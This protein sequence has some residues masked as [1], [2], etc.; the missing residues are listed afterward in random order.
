M[1]APLDLAMFANAEAIAV[2]CDWRYRRCNAEILKVSRHKRRGILA[3]AHRS[4]GDRGRNVD[5]PANALGRKV[6]VLEPEHFAALLEEDLG[7]PV[8]HHLLDLRIGVNWCG[9]VQERVEGSEA[10]LDVCLPG[11]AR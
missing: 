7:G 6:R 3:Q 10:S 5:G 11:Y 8:D 9:R 4:S 2:E 1:E